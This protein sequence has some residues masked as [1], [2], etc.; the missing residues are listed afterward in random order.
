[1]D[2]L[3]IVD[4]ECDMNSLAGLFKPERV[5]ARSS[6]SSKKRALELVSELMTAGDSGLAQNEVFTSLV[7]RERLGSTGLGHGVAIPHGRL[8]SLDRAVCAFLR[9]GDGVDFDASDGQPVNMIC[10]LL[11]PEESTSEHLNIL[12]TLAEMFSDIGFCEQI[13]GARTGAEIYQLLSS[14]SGSEARKAAG[15][16]A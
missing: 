13:H 3:T 1:M 6:V 10:G 11:V 9:L 12:A 16:P 15:P 7:E 2:A 5:A 8:K 4:V 14:W